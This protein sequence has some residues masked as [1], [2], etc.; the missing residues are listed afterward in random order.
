[1]KTDSGDQQADILD[2]SK[3]I[4]LNDFLGQ[5][6]EEQKNVDTKLLFNKYFPYKTPDKMLQTL[7]S[8]KRNAANYGEVSS[9]YGILI[10]LQTKLKR[11]SQVQI[12]HQN[13]KRC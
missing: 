11:Y 12:R 13:I 5:I 6:K 10:T 1:M 4:K 8:L 3:Q 9:I 2:T 7:Y